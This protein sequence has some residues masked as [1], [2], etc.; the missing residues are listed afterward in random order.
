MA[1]R[2]GHGETARSLPARRADRGRPRGGS[3]RSRRSAERANVVEHELHVLLFFVVLGA[4]LAAGATAGVMWA[5]G[6]QEILDR[7][8]MVQGPW[9]A[10]ALGGELLAYLGYAL[11]YREVSRVD[12]GPEFKPA[13]LAALVSTGFGA[14]IP[15]GGFS[16]DLQALEQAG[17]RRRD[18]R[19]RVLGLG[20]LEYVV[21]APAACLAAWLL[22]WRHGGEPTL[23]LTLPWAIGVP[24]GFALAAC[25][26][27]VQ[28]HTDWLR[29]GGR[30]RSALHHAVDALRV[31]VILA[32]RP[33][34][35]VLA[36]A[37]MAL[38]WLGDIFSLWAA[39]HAFTADTPRT[40]ALV[41]GYATGYALTRRTLPLA[42]AGIV[43]ALLPFALAWVGISLAPAVLAVAAY[44]VIN[45]WLPVIPAATGLRRLRSGPLS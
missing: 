19:V 36:F 14:F 2:A 35:H 34:A 11:A 41:L 39:L 38:Y 1:D 40:A 7:L 15:R 37:G 20:M 23:G 8:R 28:R 5:A 21:L 3:R 17:L 26:L 45:L 31:I 33:R 13:Q 25:G 16:V 27:W 43:E 22:V 24:V 6:F 42:G 12:K 30:I 9:L 32:K 44:R 4:A 18:A 10:A 29:D